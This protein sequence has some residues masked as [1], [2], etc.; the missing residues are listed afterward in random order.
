M[1]LAFVFIAMVM[2]T[3]ANWRRLTDRKVLVPARARRRPQRS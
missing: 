2:L 1:L 3:L